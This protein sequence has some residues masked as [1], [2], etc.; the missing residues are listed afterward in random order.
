M[1]QATGQWDG[2]PRKVEAG[3]AYAI[4]CSRND[5][6]E[7]AKVAHQLLTAADDAVKIQIYLALLPYLEFHARQQQGLAPHHAADLSE[8]FFKHARADFAAFRALSEQRAGERPTDPQ[9]VMAQ[10]IARFCA[11]DR[12]GAQA[13]LDRLRP[14]G[15]NIWE[16]VTFKPA[17]FA[18][19]EGM[20]DAQ[21]VLN[22]PPVTQIVDATFAASPVAF[23]A[24]DYAYFAAFAQPMLRS[25]NATDASAQAHVHIMDADAAQQDQAAAFCR[26]LTGPVALTVESP[27]LTAGSAAA[28]CYYHAI[29]FI[30]F[31]GALRHSAH[32]LWLMDV[33]A[34]FR[35]DPRA[36]YAELGAQDIALRIRPGRVEPWNQF[37]ACVVGAG[38]SPPSL[39]YVR[40]VAATL[41]DLHQRN[42]LRWGVDQLAMYGAFMHLRDNGHAPSVAAL[43]EQALDYEHRDDGILWCNSGTDKFGGKD[44]RRD[45]YRAL[46][47]RYA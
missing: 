3:I 47:A 29:R 23:L 31:Y 27:G 12:P 35:N 19:L 7:T 43:G 6:S 15:N 28:R 1:T 14:G 13:C 40:L 4:G 16:A 10:M 9:A 25:L 26:S 21:M 22:L 24:C 34:L 8:L 41:A 2:D 33:D 46:M 18:A 36:L 45:R 37:N 32:S 39:R 42:L 30:R 20:T 17:H 5:L 38:I 11:N 44:P